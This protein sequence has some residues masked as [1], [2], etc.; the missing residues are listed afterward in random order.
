MSKA[1][2][3]YLKHIRDECLFS[4]LNFESITDSAF[5]EVRLLSSWIKGEA[6]EYNWNLECTFEMLD[7]IDET[8]N[9]LKSVNEKIILLWES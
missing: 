3:K 4:D 9:Q 5:N 7:G 2:I 1:L 6:I 8:I